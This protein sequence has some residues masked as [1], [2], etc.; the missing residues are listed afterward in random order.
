[1]WLEFFH[2]SNPYRKAKFPILYDLM[3]V[4]HDGEIGLLLVFAELV[5]NT[6]SS[7]TK[8]EMKEGGREDER[9]KEVCEWPYSPGPRKCKRAERHP[10]RPQSTARPPGCTGWRWVQRRWQT[11]A[12]WPWWSRW[13][14][15]LQRW[16][17][18]SPAEVPQSSSS[19]SLLTWVCLCTSVFI[20]TYTHTV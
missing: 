12:H 17:G 20:Y 16:D 13:W 11:C 6:M 4:T 7:L 3:C 19:F 1:M 10:C 14:W 15:L 8:G 18:N 2:P 9:K 5:W